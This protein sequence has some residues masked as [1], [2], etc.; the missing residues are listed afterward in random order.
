MSQCQMYLSGVEGF[1]SLDPVYNIPAIY[2]A[3]VIYVAAKIDCKEIWGCLEST[4]KLVLAS[5]LR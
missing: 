1:K 2:V 4:S 3:V 5:S